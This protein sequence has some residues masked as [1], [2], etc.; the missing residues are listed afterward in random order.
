MQVLS[1]T[2]STHSRPKAAGAIG[3]I[4]RVCVTVSTHSRPKAA[5]IEPPKVVV[6]LTG[7]NTQPPEGGWLR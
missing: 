1:R 4:P 6:E 5:G 3:A 2:V 7:F